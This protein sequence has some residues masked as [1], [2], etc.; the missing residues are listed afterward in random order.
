[1]ELIEEVAE[2]SLGGAKGEVDGQKKRLLA[3]KVGEEEDEVGVKEV[4][5]AQPK[6][7]RVADG[8]HKFAQR[9]VA[10]K[11]REG[12]LREPINRFAAVNICA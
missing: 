6:R 7:L 8:G 10:Q 11:T 4:L 5:I 3:K 12:Q 2:G 9:F 1:M